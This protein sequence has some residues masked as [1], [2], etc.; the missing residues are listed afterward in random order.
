MRRADN[1]KKMKIVDR[2]EG[3]NMSKK[4]FRIYLSNISNLDELKKSFNCSRSK[5]K[6][7]QAKFER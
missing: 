5:L 4:Q 3:T 2:S 7:K 6:G 1:E